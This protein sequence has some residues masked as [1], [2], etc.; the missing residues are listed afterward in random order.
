MHAAA[1]CTHCFP[2]RRLV[3]A[4]KWVAVVE[5]PNSLV[6]HLKRFHTPTGLPSSGAK[7]GRH[8]AFPLELALPLQVLQDRCAFLWCSDERIGAKELELVA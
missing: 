5:P 2:C 1:A 6:I 8:V 4:R 3:R 7:I